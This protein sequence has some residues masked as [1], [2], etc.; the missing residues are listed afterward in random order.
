[1]IVVNRS[2]K[3]D[4]QGKRTLKVMLQCPTCH[5]TQTEQKDE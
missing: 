5:E 3:Y 2:V 4:K 1:M